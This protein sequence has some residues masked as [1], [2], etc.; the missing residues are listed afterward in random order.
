MKSETISRIIPFYRIFETQT[1]ANLLRFHI[2]ASF[3]LLLLF[4]GSSTAS[5]DFSKELIFQLEPDCI[6]PEGMPSPVWLSE[7]ATNRDA[8]ADPLPIAQLNLPARARTHPEL[9][10]IFRLAVP[11]GQDPNLWLRKLKA[12]PGVVWAEPNPVRHTDAL[13]APPRDF[14][15]NDPLYHLQWSLPRIAAPAAWD[16]CRGDTNVTIAIVD[17]GVDLDHGDL[18]SK[19]W[20]NRAEAAGEPGVDDDGNGFVDDVNGWDFRD[21]DPDPRPARGDEHGTH[22]AGITAAATDNGYGIAGVA[23][24]CRIMAVRAGYGNTITRGYEAVIYAV[25]AGADVISLSWGGG[26]ASTVERIAT[27]YAAEEG[28]LIVAAAGNLETSG[29]EIHFPAAYDRVLS[30]AATGD[31]DQLAAFSNRGSWVKICA[32]G[33]T[34]LSLLPGNS[35]GAESGTSMA[36]PMVAGAAALLKSL[37]PEWT[38]DQI[39]LQL[40]LTAD[41]VDDLN[42]HYHGEMGSGRLNLYR[43]LTGGPAGFAITGWNADDRLG[44]D[45]D[46]IIDPGEEIAL[47]VTLSNLLTRSANIVGTLTTEASEI[48]ILSARADFG[49]IQPGTSAANTDRPFRIEVA[50]RVIAGT[51]IPCRLNLAGT[52][53]EQS[54]PLTLTVRPSYDDLDT[55]KVTLT[56]TDF[57]ALGYYDY[58]HE[59]AVGQ[60]FRY[61]RNGV[62]ALFHGSLMVGV[63][64]GRVS[65]CAYGNSG[66]NH[67]DFVPSYSGF[68]VEPDSSSG[69]QM[70]RAIFDDSNAESPLRIR[71]EQESYAFPDPPDDAFVILNYTVTNRSNTRYDSLYIGLFLDW[72]LIQPEENTI[73]WDGNTGV[74]WVEYTPPVFPVFGTA[75][76]SPS[77]TF[78]SALDNSLLLIAWDDTTK[79]EHILSGFIEAEGLEER[80]WSQLIGVGPLSVSPNNT[81]TATFVMAAGN[82]RDDLFANVQAARTRWGS[83]ALQHEPASQPSQFQLLSLYPAPFNSRMVARC[84]TSQA[85]PV[86]WRLS[87]PFGRSL[88]SGL[89]PVPAPGTYALNLNLLAAPSGTYLLTL[90][91]GSSSLSSPVV[92][93][94]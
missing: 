73:H 67:F 79:M 36:T 2:A 48:A 82:D 45:G 78:Q 90:T 4:V 42:P 43:A 64:L 60:G 70:G 44:G 75:L 91:Q 92:L 9:R 66:R 86:T 15:P 51:E 56:V 35:F 17:V 37:H 87:D 28:A 58:P 41:P 80:D 59:T 6:S 23:W 8:A 33:E 34:I 85:G 13:P 26:D 30:V 27:D 11:A 39:R 18:R 46:G 61:P 31:G 89:L 10:R 77:A 5:D 19:L 94:K 22:V 49:Q 72:D 88:Q 40:T 53:P 57:G 63:P 71:V 47:N 69:G 74:G 81:A 16:V 83:I 25:T 21:D 54:L 1:R 55:G 3:L 24:N 93:I 32:P 62:S 20:I 29:P 14:H 68:R 76:I 52:T 7:V 65:D 12:A 38:P 84:R 50:S